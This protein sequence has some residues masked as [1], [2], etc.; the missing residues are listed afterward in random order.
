M[1]EKKLSR[2]QVLK[3]ASVAAVGFPYIVSSSVLGNS[4]RPA[5]NSRINV[6]CIGCGFQGTWIVTQFLNQP[7]AQL[8]AI[9]D[10][11]QGTNRYYHDKTCGLAPTKKLIEEHYAKQAPSGTYKGCATY[12]D[13]RQMLERKD[14]DAVCVVTPDHW[15]GLMAVAAAQAGKHI[16]CEKPLTKSVV[17]GQAIRE[18]IRKS[19]RV[20]QTGSHERSRT[21]VRIGC[22]LVH[23]GRI[24]KVHTIRVH[25]PLDDGHH[26]EAI[27]FGKQ[28]HPTEPVPEG[29]D[30]DFWLGP[31]AY[32]PYTPKRCH[33]WWRWIFDYG[34]GEM[35]DRGAHV[36]DVAQLGIKADDTGPIELSGKGKP[37]ESDLFNTFIEYEFECTY[38]NGIKLY[39]DSAGKRGVTFEGS[40]GW[41]S[42][43]LH[44]GDLKAEP[45]SILDEKV[46]LPFPN[47]DNSR[48]G[49][50]QR[51]FLDAIRKGT[52]PNASFEAGHRT[53]T[54]CNLLNV[55]MLTGR[56]LKW[57]PEKEQVID[58][59]EAA[60]MLNPPM[61]E[62]WK[63]SV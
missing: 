41:L 50:H 52:A 39:G 35:T 11:D 49:A 26:R 34:G 53:S 36:L 6:A 5:P 12:H 15:H 51:S 14:I 4:D 29:F 9:C 45:A 38:A 7:D 3:S 17:E 24:G 37:F 40:D 31:A 47:S 54:L 19:N 2:R 16:Y 18:A 63:L 44:G 1:S 22:E 10:V 58:D 56:K 28:P 48:A 25:M 46:E 8:V 13:F 42:I 55:A 21:G 27:E 60:R 57:D 33:F 32:K 23:R 43:G 61:R 20:F 62:P 30:Y 59:P